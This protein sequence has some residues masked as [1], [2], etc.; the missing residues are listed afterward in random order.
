MHEIQQKIDIFEENIGI[1]CEEKN[2]VFEEKLKEENR[3]KF[4]KIKEEL[5]ENR[6]KSDQKMQDFE[7][8]YD[9]MREESDQ[10]MQ[11]FERM[12]GGLLKCNRVAVKKGTRKIH[13]HLL[14][15]VARRKIRYD[16]QKCK[17]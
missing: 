4:D 10:K 6:E 7:R 8:K 1:K 16:S 5:E 13:F 3:Q 14:N 11:D 12:S 17:I 9:R 2:R 15:Y